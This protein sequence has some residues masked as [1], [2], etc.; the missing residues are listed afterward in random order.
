[1]SDEKVNETSTPEV[2]VAPVMS[3][4]KKDK[5]PKAATV[6]PEAGATVAPVEVA[7]VVEAVAKPATEKAVKAPKAAGADL[8]HD[9]S[10]ELEG[11]TDDEVAIKLAKTLLDGESFS[12]F[13]LGGVVAVIM[14]KGFWEGKGYETLRKWIEGELG[15]DYRKA[16]HLKDIYNN[17]VASAV[18]WEKVKGLGWTKLIHLSDIMT[19]ENVDEWVA[20]A[21]HP[22]T[23]LQVIEMVKAFKTAAL[24][25]PEG[26]AP[27]AV[28]TAPETVS[29]LTFKVHPDQKDDINA[30]VAKAMGDINTTFPAVGLHNMAMSYIEKATGAPTVPQK[31]MEQMM[32]E[33]GWEKTLEIFAQVYPGVNLTVESVT[34]GE[35]VKAEKAA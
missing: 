30:A 14:T 29:T 16:M 3:F 31:S 24:I 4:L 13:K 23:V 18:P 9:T 2:P 27:A 25:T 11:I 20:K 15:M 21:S 6:A 1:M 28:P 34:S 32:A 12:D 8:I 33:A 17:L 10:T 19:L 22:V 7:K 35:A 5:K 26:A